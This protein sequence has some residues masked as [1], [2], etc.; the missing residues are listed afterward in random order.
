VKII[1][2]TIFGLRARDA[3]PG[4]SGLRARVVETVARAV[5]ILG[6]TPA[7]RME[8]LLDTQVTAAAAEDVVA[9]LGEALS[10]TAR[11]AQASRVEV[12]LAA[13]RTDLTVTVEDDGVGIPDQVPRSGLANL[14][15]RAQGHGGV[16]EIGP[17]AAGG[18]RLL[19]RVPLPRTAAE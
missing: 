18:T 4:G 1:R 9:V 7:L 13:S 16:L 19:W 5:P 6:F 12:T 10:N 15:E 17:G 11:H 14:A 2:T 8:G 3:G